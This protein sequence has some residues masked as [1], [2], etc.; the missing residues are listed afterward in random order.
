M[1]Y[2]PF[3]LWILVSGAWLGCTIMCAIGFH[4]NPDTERPFLRWMV[5]HRRQTGRGMVVFLPISVALLILTAAYG[6]RPAMT[7]IG[8]LTGQQDVLEDST[9][10]A[11]VFAESI[12][13]PDTFTVTVDDPGLAG[14]ALRT[15][16]STP[17]SRRG[18]QVDMAQMQYESYRFVLG[19]ETVTFS[20][21]PHSY[22]C[23]DG[24]DYELGENR[25]AALCDSVHEWAAQQ[26]DARTPQSAWYGE[27]AV[28]RTDFVDN[29]DEARSVTELTLSAGGKSVCGIIEG[30]YDV[31]SVERQ[32]DGYVIRYTYGDFYSHE[33]IRTSRV[34][35]ENGRM[36]IT[37]MA[38]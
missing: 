37:G 28:L 5:T 10:T 22:F 4:A 33:A 26:G 19:E 12:G 2:L 18:C 38:Q 15:I 23:Y 25:L 8:Q 1:R 9:P 30:A 16:L 7:T 20:F 36:I 17:V 35:V 11:L 34:T 3:I 6:E 24:Q 21:L 14:R 31:L 29:G 32:P 27:D 13:A